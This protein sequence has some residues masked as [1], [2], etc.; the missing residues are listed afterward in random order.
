MEQRITSHPLNLAPN[1]S[2]KG[3]PLFSVV[4]TKEGRK[5]DALL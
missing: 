3:I 5:A 1:S 4:C 2:E